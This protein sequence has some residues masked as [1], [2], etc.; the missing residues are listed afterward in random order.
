MVNP[1]TVDKEFKDLITLLAEDEYK[2]LEQNIIE[3]GCLDNIKTWEGIII[4]GHNR[5][6]ICE[7]HNLSFGVTELLFSTREE[8]IN[9]I[10]DNQ[11][12]RRNLTPWQMSVLRGKRYEAEKKEH[13]GDRK[14]MYQNDTLI[15]TREELSDQ[16]GVSPAT[17]QSVS[18]P[19]GNAKASMAKLQSKLDRKLSANNCT[20]S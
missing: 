19:L 15:S 16:Y 8:V 12:G 11:L 18:I 7:K 4:D 20:K 6:E 3:R 1:L 13:G 2:G 10:I 14:S 9:W 5:Y 17:I